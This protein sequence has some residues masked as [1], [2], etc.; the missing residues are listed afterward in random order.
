MRCDVSIARPNADIFI[1]VTATATPRMRSVATR[2]VTNA[3][4][5]RFVTLVPLG[6]FVNPMGRALQQRL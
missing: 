3:R 2:P 6:Q 4:L 5:A 1:I